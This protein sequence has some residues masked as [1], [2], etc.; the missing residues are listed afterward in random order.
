M[1]RLYG[2]AHVPTHGLARP[3]GRDRSRWRRAGAPPL[4]GTFSR[5]RARPRAR[6]GAGRCP[7]RRV[8]APNVAQVHP[9]R[10][11]RQVGS[12]RRRILFPRRSAFQRLASR[13]PPACQ[14]IAAQRE[15]AATSRVQSECGRYY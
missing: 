5:S 14:N 8:G 2:V 9:H 11:G 3:L 13:A 6:F 10:K 4:T 12:R 1:G 15:S 7:G